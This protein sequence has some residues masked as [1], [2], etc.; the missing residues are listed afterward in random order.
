MKKVSYS[1]ML[2]PNTGR[3]FRLQLSPFALR[4][5]LFSIVFLIAAAAWGIFSTST[6]Y[7][8]VHIP[9]IKVDKTLIKQKLAAEEEVARLRK[10]LS[11]ERDRA[12]VFARNLGQM[13]AGLSRLDA[14]GSR[15]ISVVGLDEAEFDFVQRPAFGGPRPIQRSTSDH[16]LDLMETRERLN[17]HLENVDVQLT[18]IEYLLQQKR[19]KESARPH[20]WPTDGGHLSSN[21]GFRR[22]PFTGRIS[23]HK[24]IDI[25]NRYGAAVV[26]ASRGIVVFAGK[27]N[28]YGY[29]VE[30]LHGFGYKT[31][32]GH[33]SSILVQVGDVVEDGQSVARIGN[34]G[35]ST[36]PHLHYEVHRYGEHMNPKGFIPKSK[37]KKS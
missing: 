32:Y 11:F 28:G 24:G 8:Q 6:H 17:S 12:A 37:A 35:R 2:V 19:T 1:L 4:F 26:A 25:G 20:L 21:Y 23:S 30:L 15:L 7:E 22:D 18:A 14:L 29:T 13:Q 27:K 10:E 9:F 33:L 31:R 36:G 34:S 16:H 3:V 5:L